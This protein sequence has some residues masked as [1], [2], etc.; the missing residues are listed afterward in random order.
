MEWTTNFEILPDIATVSI[1][2]ASLRFWYAR[3][4]PYRADFLFGFSSTLG[5]HAGHVL[6]RY[7]RKPTCWVDHAIAAGSNIWKCGYGPY[8][9]STLG[10]PTD[11]ELDCLLFQTNFMLVPK[12]RKLLL[13]ETLGVQSVPVEQFNVAVGIR[14]RDQIMQGYY[15]LSYFYF[16]RW[17]D[18]L[19]RTLETHIK[20]LVQGCPVRGLDPRPFVL[21]GF[22]VGIYSFS[23]VL[24]GWFLEPGFFLNIYWFQGSYPNIS[25]IRD[26]FC[27]VQEF[28][29][30]WAPVC[31]YIP[32][33]IRIQVRRVPDHSVAEVEAKSDLSRWTRFLE[34]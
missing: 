32:K 28:L 14:A 6:Y 2:K 3:N 11:K 13:P 27:P 16:Y 24:Y 17:A 4:P 34:G 29:L 7:S 26:F 9:I 12:K 15:F 20:G 5:S 19:P 30:S 1:G 22:A 21:A 33:N 23:F 8:R 10:I 25:V 18:E 31:A